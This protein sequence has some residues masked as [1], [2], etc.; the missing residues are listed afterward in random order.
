MVINLPKD[1]F[2]KKKKIY[3]M[4]L[5]TGVGQHL[6]MNQLGFIYNLSQILSA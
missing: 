6:L 2:K 1:I 5:L 3:R 4:T